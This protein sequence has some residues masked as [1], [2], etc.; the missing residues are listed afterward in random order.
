M[1]FSTE[2]IITALKRTS[3]YTNTSEI[4]ILGIYLYIIVSFSLELY[5]TISTTICL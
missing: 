5:Y 2:I 1:E 4:Y 3:I